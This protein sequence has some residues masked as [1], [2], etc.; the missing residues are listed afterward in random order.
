MP[1]ASH[2]VVAVSNPHHPGLEE[3][4]ARAKWQ[5]LRL[6]RHQAGA[7]A[8]QPH[9]LH[10]RRRLAEAR[11]RAHAW[12][13]RI[14]DCGY[15][16]SKAS[17]L[18]YEPPRQLVLAPFLSRS[19]FPPVW[20]RCLQLPRAQPQEAR[21]PEAA[22]RFNESGNA[23]KLSVPEA[24]TSLPEDVIPADHLPEAAAKYHA[25]ALQKSMAS[26][27]AEVQWN[28]MVT[29]TFKGDA[30]V[31]HA[32]ATKIFGRFRNRYRKDVLR[33]NRQPNMAAVIENSREML[34]NVGI[35]VDGREG[36]H[37]HVLLRVRE[38]D[39]PYKYKDA[40]EHAWK[41]TNRLCGDPK[42]CCPD[43]NKWY[44]PLTSAVERERYT[45]YMLK[46]NG[47][48]AFGLIVP[49]LNLD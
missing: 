31:S 42:V 41:A 47:T 32:L 24:S 29:L 2:T 9:S 19:W 23:G 33:N 26:W 34:K 13:I 18:A 15:E 30:G 14:G 40:I 49:Y 27:L 25:T 5:L 10:Q 3:V 21:T 38:G 11:K 39:D 20:T 8:P 28:L 48:D 43:S 4:R 7:G 6:E 35:E 17:P 12:R 16:Q 1:A 37:I 45:G 36:T 44:L 22:V 46:H